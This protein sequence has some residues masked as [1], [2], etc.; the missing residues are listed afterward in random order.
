MV[1][2]HDH[3]DIVI[4]EYCCEGLAIKDSSVALLAFHTLSTLW[5]YHTWNKVND[6]FAYRDL[7]TSIR[8]E[9]AIMGHSWP[10]IGPWK[11]VWVLV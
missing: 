7:R 2:S 10:R 11:P 4:H 8:A 6:S 9:Q 3:S 5:A 1:V